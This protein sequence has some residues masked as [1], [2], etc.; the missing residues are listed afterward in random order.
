[1]F[2]KKQIDFLKKKVKKGML[3]LDIGA[4]IGFYSLLLSK[5][6]GE[7]G[8]VYAFEPE[9][10]NFKFLKLNSLKHKNITPINAAVGAS[11]GIIKLYISKDLNVD[12]HTYDIG[13]GR[14]YKIV[15]L[16]T[17][18][19]YFKLKKKFDVIKL[20][21]QGFDYQAI[22]GMRETIKNTDKI[23]LLGEYWPYGLKKAG[24]NPKKYLSLLRKMKFHITFHEKRIIKNEANELNY[25]D[26]YAIKGSI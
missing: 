2:E 1:M 24:D 15:K 22:L 18:D 19:G 23:L 12:H 5:L 8:K 14:K 25:Q 20:D 26:F 6:V 9:E 13:E 21:I 3:I 4:N 11:N 10:F 17:I 16:V 7:K